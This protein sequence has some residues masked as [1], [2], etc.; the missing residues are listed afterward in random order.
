[1][2]SFGVSWSCLFR[3]A[4]LKQFQQGNCYADTF[5]PMEKSPQKNNRSA[6]EIQV[7][8]PRLAPDE[9]Y[10]SVQGF[11]V[12]TETYHLRRGYCCKSQCRHCPYEKKKN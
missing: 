9:Y 10:Y 11:L 5:L 4:K 12:F 8:H 1:M 6:P 3:G 2:H 7:A